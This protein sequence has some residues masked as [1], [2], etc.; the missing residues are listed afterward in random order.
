[1]KKWLKMNSITNK[2]QIQNNK[3]GHSKKWKKRKINKEINRKDKISNLMINLIKC[4]KISDKIHKCN[5]TN[6]EKSF[7]NNK[8]DKNKNSK[9]KINKK[10]KMRTIKIR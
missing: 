3:L 7:N 4:L 8:K 2:N 10:N 9:Y 1:M 6:K 5:L